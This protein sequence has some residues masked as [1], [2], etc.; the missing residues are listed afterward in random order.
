MIHRLARET[1]ASKIQCKFSLFDLEEQKVDFKRGSWFSQPAFLTTVS[2]TNIVNFV[3]KERRG[4]LFEVREIC[5]GFEIWPVFDATVTQESS[6]FLAL[7]RKNFRRR[8]MQFSLQSRLDFRLT[9]R[10]FKWTSVFPWKNKKLP[11]QLEGEV[12]F[13]GMIRLERKKNQIVCMCLFSKF[14]DYS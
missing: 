12:S 6:Q 8:H 9:L 11:W 4:Y 14:F 7:D 2:C 3:T 10:V 1:V 13:L 5:R